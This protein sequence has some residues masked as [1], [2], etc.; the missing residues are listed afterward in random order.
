MIDKQT[1]TNMTSDSQTATYPSFADSDE[2]RQ[3]LISMH[4]D[5]FKDANGFRP[6]S[7]YN[8]EMISNEEIESMLDSLS[9]EVSKQIDEEKAYAASQV[10]V[11]KAE[12]ARYQTE[13]GAKDLETAVRWYL[14]GAGELYNEQ[15]IEGIFWKAGI[16]FTPYAKEMM[17][18]FAQVA[19]KYDMWFDWRAAEAAQNAIPEMELEE[20]YF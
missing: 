2:T 12:L 14:E 11:F 7:M 9:A 17:P 6:R 10:E 13:F 1:D 3:D 16:L 4:S 5:M 19:E 8:W 20:I 18:V 15:C